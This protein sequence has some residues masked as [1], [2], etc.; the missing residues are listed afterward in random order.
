MKK[1]V[2]LLA[3]CMVFSSL[4]LSAEPKDKTDKADNEKVQR[5]LDKKQKESFIP[6]K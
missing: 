3:G 5:I 1:L 6:L 4:A 2:L